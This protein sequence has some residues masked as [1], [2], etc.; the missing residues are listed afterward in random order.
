MASLS[1]HKYTNLKFLI[2][3]IK[4]N[5]SRSNIAQIARQISST[6]I[7]NVHAPSELEKRIAKVS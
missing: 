4:S 2:K 6:N 7:Y 1:V 5:G 3:F